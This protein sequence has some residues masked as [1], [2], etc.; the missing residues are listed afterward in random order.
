MAFKGF[1]VGIDRYASPDV[2]WLTCATR[3]ARALHAIFSDNL[4]AD[5]KLFTD[6]EATRAAIQ[7]EFQ[8]LAACRI[9]CHA[10]ALRV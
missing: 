8:A 6:Q 7:H 1:F 10:V 4:G 2:N 9:K 5:A 3:D